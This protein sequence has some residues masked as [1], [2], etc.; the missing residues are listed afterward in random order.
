[1]CAR[2]ANAPTPLARPER[3]TSLARALAERF[4]HEA[5]RRLGRRV[6]RIP[7][8]ALEALVAREWPG[9]VR[10]LENAIERCVI[11]SLG[12]ELELHLDAPAPQACAAKPSAS[13]AA[14]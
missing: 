5:A 6:E 4:M 2:G 9:N 11:R 7:G 8:P 1:M 3:V 10:E 14:S 13:A 12:P